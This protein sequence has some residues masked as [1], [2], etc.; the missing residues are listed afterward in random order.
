MTDRY[1]DPFRAFYD[2]ALPA[3]YGYLRTRLAD[4]SRVEDVTQEVFVSA[5]RARD[6][7]DSSKGSLA[8][9]LMG[10]T[11]NRLIDNVRAEQ[12]HASRRS[13]SELGDLPTY[14]DVDRVG[15]KM[16]VADALKSLPERS[17]TLIELSFFSDLTHSQ[18]AEQTQVPL[19]TVKSDIRRGLAR[20][21]R[22]LEASD[23]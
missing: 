13:T 7:F 19:G 4:L 22:H 2:R 1:G 3:V 8:A 18:I 9:W 16:L 11:K 15:D 23:A 12:R 17:R 10:I 6:R 21:R 5:W 14:S 20:I